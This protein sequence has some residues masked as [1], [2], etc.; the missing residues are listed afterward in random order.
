MPKL[1]PIEAR[2]ILNR[3]RI[4]NAVAGG[5]QSPVYLLRLPDEK[6]DRKLY[7]AVNAV[8]ET[9]GGKWSRGAKAHVFP[10]DPRL[11]ISAATATGAYTD[12]KSDLNQFF[13]PPR[14]ADRI[15]ELAFSYSTGEVETILEPSAGAGAIV[16]AALKRW[17]DAHI[18][19]V[20]TDS[21]LARTL[22]KKWLSGVSVIRG[23]FIT[24][25][26]NAGSL[27]DHYDVVV[28]NPPWSDQRAAKHVLAAWGTVRPGGVLVA[29]VPRGL[30]AA[31]R[32]VDNKAFRQADETYG[33]HAEEIPEGAFKA[34]GTGVGGDIVVWRKP[35]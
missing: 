33:V 30:R 20:E 14:L 1:I 35:A 32:G 21:D 25:V 5:G 19:A 11:A 3:V 24:E 16:D 12:T 15:C 18:D 28:M 8:L 7:T 4:E 34:S 9:M 2:E 23:D 13:S 22:A 29:A 31:T 17:P 27:C 10:T 26:A 6:L